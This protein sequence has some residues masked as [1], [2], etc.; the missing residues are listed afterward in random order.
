MDDVASLLLALAV[1]A[2]SLFGATVPGDPAAGHA[3]TE[4]HLLDRSPK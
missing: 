3:A 2:A 1:A 4:F